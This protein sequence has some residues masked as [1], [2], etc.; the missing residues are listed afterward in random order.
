MFSFW[1]PLR[2]VV[3]NACK[4]TGVVNSIVKVILGKLKSQ[5]ENPQHS[6]TEVKDFAIVVKEGRLEARVNLLSRPQVVAVHVGII[7]GEDIIWLGLTVTGKLVTNVK[8]LGEVTA[9]V[10]VDI[11]GLVTAKE[12]RVATEALQGTSVSSALRESN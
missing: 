1:D 5:S 12:G 2:R 8:R 11:S 3:H 9:W 10:L 6:P 4:R 7:F